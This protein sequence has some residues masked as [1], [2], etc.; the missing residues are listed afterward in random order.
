MGTKGGTRRARHGTSD[1]VGES[2]VGDRGTA[3]VKADHYRLPK[4][5]RKRGSGQLLSNQGIREFTVK[6]DLCFMCHVVLSLSLRLVFCC[7]LFWELLPFIKCVRT[8]YV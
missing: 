4:G 1:Y 7:A 3:A 6:D 2:V 5:G 8:L